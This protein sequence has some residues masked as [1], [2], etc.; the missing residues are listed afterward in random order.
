MRSVLFTILIAI[1]FTFNFAEDLSDEAFYEFVKENPAWERK[2]ERTI[3][4]AAK[5]LGYNWVEKL[6]DFLEAK[7]A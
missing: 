6:R 7:Q 3:R 2:D 5:R 1:I 4:I